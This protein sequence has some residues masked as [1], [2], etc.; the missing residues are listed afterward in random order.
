[1]SRSVV[2]KSGPRCPH[3]QLPS[4][5]C[6]CA[7]LHA[8]ACPLQ[9][10][11]LMHHRESWKP[12]STG[13]LV[14]RTLTGSRLHIWRREHGLT[15]ADVRLPGR[16]LWILHPAGQPMPPNLDTAAIQI[17]LLDGAWRESSAMA[18]EVGSWGRLTSLPMSGVSRYW[19]R[20]QQEGG[21]FSTV[22]ALLFLLEAFG[23]ASMSHD[24][25]LQFELHVYAGLRARGRKA[26]AEEFLRD[27]PIG[28]A[29]PEVLAQ[30]ETRRLR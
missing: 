7:G 5:W 25:R 2:L 30:L 8:I 10:D 15:A 22:E 26:E 24:L 9:V 29:L 18:Q 17:L 16:D 19:L 21:R 27:S 3:C 13:R 4:R 12:T 1:M 14:N 20:A 11:V 28:V 23:L 6:I